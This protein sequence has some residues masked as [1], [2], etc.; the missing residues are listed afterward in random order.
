MNANQDPGKADPLSKVLAE[1]KVDAPL[2]PRFQEQVWQRLAQAERG[3]E[4]AA[5][6]SLW[7]LIEVV[8]PRPGFA[9]SYLAALVVFGVVAGSWAAQI[10]TSRMDSKLGLRYVQTIDPY[11]GDSAQP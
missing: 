7:R 10:E 1:W 8:L 4:P 3:A 11:R 9:Y 6:G 2:P 5:Q